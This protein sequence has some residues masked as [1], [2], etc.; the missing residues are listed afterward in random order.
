MPPSGP[1]RYL[2]EDDRIYIADRA[3]GEGHG[4]GDSRGAGPQAVHLSRE[5][6]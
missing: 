5:G 3:A 1:S 6:E 2:R 4:P